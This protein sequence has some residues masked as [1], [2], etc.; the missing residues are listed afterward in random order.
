[1]VKRLHPQPVARE[2]QASARMI[3]DREGEP[4][5]EPRQAVGPPLAPRGDADFGIAAGAETMA[6]ILQFG[7]QF[8]AIVDF[9][10]VGDR[11]GFVIARHRLR[12][13]PDDDDRSSE[14]VRVG[15]AVCR[16]C[17]SRWYAK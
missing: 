14:E 1:M 7:A 9:A 12:A 6:A 2:E 15:E 5:V 16:T 11:D 3:V 4:A 17:R 8:A 10:V 13:A